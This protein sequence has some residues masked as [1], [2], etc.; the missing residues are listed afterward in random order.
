MTVDEIKALRERA[1]DL[2]RLRSDGF[3][4]T[5]HTI[6]LA[7]TELLALLT[8]AERAEGLRAAA[9]DALPWM[10][11]GG[12]ASEPWEALRAALAAFGETKP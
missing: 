9:D 7:P 5:F 4:K 8:I 12:R 11:R 1:Q 3:Q 2:V 6:S 10:A